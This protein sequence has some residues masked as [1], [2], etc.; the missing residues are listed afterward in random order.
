MRGI[1]SVVLLY[2]IVLSKGVHGQ[3]GGGGAPGPSGGV[4]PF[5][6]SGVMYPVRGL[7]SLFT[8]L[9]S[10]LILMGNVVGRY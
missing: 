7:Y 10:I 5:V 4:E 1:I 6:K 2:V 3:G 9:R 8:S